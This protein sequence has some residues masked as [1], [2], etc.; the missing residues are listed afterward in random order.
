[1]SSRNSLSY[2]ATTGSDSVDQ[3]IEIDPSKL[4]GPRE[5][6]IS[7][8]ETNTWLTSRLPKWIE[9]RSHQFPSQV[10]NL[11]ATTEAKFIVIRFKFASEEISQLVSMDL[12][13]NFRPDGKVLLKLNSLKGGEL[14]L[15]LATLTGALQKN[16]GAGRIKDVV[17]K[18]TNIFDGEVFDTRFDLDKKRDLSVV[19]VDF[20]D[21]KVKLGLN[22]VPRKKA[23][24]GA[25]DQQ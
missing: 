12:D 22:I 8:K 15:P 25:S 14:P 6:V 1:M 24:A 10:S 16:A 2:A 23:L 20:G 11:M 4:I 3:G 13:A 7:R 19:G 9:S 17:D 21:D 18:M 5:L